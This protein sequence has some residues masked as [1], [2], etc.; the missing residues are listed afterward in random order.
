MIYNNLRIE[1]SMT[2][3]PPLKKKKNIIT[4]LLIEGSNNSGV[5]YDVDHTIYSLLHQCL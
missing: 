2:T 3:T 1:S 5:Q 4:I